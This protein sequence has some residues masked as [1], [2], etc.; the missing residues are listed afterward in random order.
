MNVK[1]VLRELKENKIDIALHNGDIRLSSDNPEIPAAMIRQIREMKKEVID[2]LK[3]HI[4]DDAVIDAIPLLPPQEDYVLSSSQMRLWMVT[5]LA[6][7]GTAYNMNGVYIFKGQ[8][9]E[10]ALEYAFNILMARHESLRT[11]FRNNTSGEVRQVIV[12]L[13]ELEFSLGRIDLRDRADRKEHVRQLLDAAFR[14]P[15]DLLKGPLIRACIYRLEDDEWVFSY[16][17]DH[18]ITDG[19]SMDILFGELQLLYNARISGKENPLSPLRIQYKD[20]AS[21][22]QR[23]FQKPS[24]KRQREYWMQQFA[25]NV[26]VL[27]MPVDKPRPMVKSFRGGEMR[28]YISAEKT[29][30]LRDLCQAEGSTLFMGLLAVINTLIYR[31]SE[32][33]DIVIGSPIAGRVH[34]DLEDQIGFYV[35]TLA[36]RTRISGKDTFR[37]LLTT[38]RDITLGAYQNQ[39][40]PFDELVANLPIQRDM[41]RNP[42]FDVVVALLNHEI[43]GA[44]KKQRPANFEATP[45]KTNE[46]KISKFDLSFVFTETENGL[47]AY[48]EYNTDV[49]LEDSIRQM[50]GYFENL[51]DAILSQPDQSIGLLPLLNEQQQK[52]L[53]I[54]LQAPMVAVQEEGTRPGEEAATEKTVVRLFEEQVNKTPDAIALIFEENSLTYK[55]L[56][57]QANRVAHYL[58]ESC[59]IVPDD[60]VGVRLQRSHRMIVALLGIL[61]AGGAY[62]PIDPEYPD[63][64]VQ[65]I[66][67]DSRCTLLLEEAELKKALTGEYSGENPTAVNIPSHLA[68]VIYTSGSTGLPKGVMVEHKSIVRLVK[69][70]DFVPLTGR[71]TLL[72]TGSLSFDATIFEFW[73][74]LLN[75]GR[76]ILCT[77]QTLLNGTVLEQLIRRWGVDTMWF[78]VSFFNQL[79]SRNI[80]VFSG[81]KTILI[82]GEKLSAE[83]IRILKDRYP[84]VKIINGYGPTENTVFTLTCEIHSAGYIPIGKPMRNTYA[85][86]LNRKGQLQ[87]PGMM[88]EIC[89]GGLGVARGYLYRPE[90]TAEKFV[91]DPYLPGARLYRTGDLGR[92]LP[93]GN[94]EFLGRRDDQLKIRGFRIEPGEIESVLLRH[95]AVKGAVVVAVPNR[96]G[97]KELAAYLVSEE[98]LHVSELRSWLSEALPSYMLPVHY[99]QLSELPLTANGKVDKRALPHPE[100]MEMATGKKYV[101]PR[102]EIETKLVAIWQEMLSRERISVNDDFFELGGHSLKVFR[103]ASVLDKE[104]GVKLKMRDLFMHV[105]LGAQAMLIERAQKGIDAPGQQVEGTDGIKHE[106]PVVVPIEN[107]PLTPDY[108]LSSGQHRLWVLQRFSEDSVAY[109]VPYAYTLRGKIE[110]DL[111]ERALGMIVERHEILRTVFREDGSGEVRQLVLP[112]NASG[113]I[114]VREDVRDRIDK[115]EYIKHRVERM[116][117]EAFDLAKGPLVRTGLFRVEDNEWVFC[118]V[119]H[120]IIVD[121]W[122]M[123]VLIREFSQL[124]TEHSGQVMA[125]INPLPP[126]RIQYKDYAHWQQEQL[127]GQVMKAHR[128]YW[129]RQF[130]GEL[131][132]LELTGS[133][134]RRQL[135]SYRGGKVRREL[136]T[137]EL[138]VLKKFCREEGGTLFMGLLSVLNMLLYRYSG[139]QDIIV[140]SPIAGRDNADLEDQVGFYVNTLALRNRFE[141]TDDFR[142]L[143]QKV[144]KTTLEAYEHHP[145]PFDQLVNALPLQRGMGRNPLFDVLIDFSNL[146]ETIHTQMQQRWFKDFE[147]EKFGAVAP[148]ISKVDLT[149]FLEENNGA[150]SL[151]IE[152]DSDLYSK[153][154]VE[155]MCVHYQQLLEAV[156]AD[157]S[158][159]IEQIDILDDLEKQILKDFNKP[160]SAAPGYTNVVTLFNRQAAA[161]PEAVAVEFGEHRLTYRELNERS[162]ALAAYFADEYSIRPGDLIGIMLPRS[163][164]LIVAILATLK[165]G[166]AFVPLDPEYPATRKKFIIEDTGVKLMVIQADELATL[167]YYEGQ[168]FAIDI[169]LDA[170]VPATP[171]AMPHILPGNTAYLI[172]TSGS[173]GKPKGC[174]IAHQSFANYIQ[175]ANRYYFPEGLIPNFSLFTPV[176]FDLTITSIFCTL[177]SGGTL[178]IY[179]QHADIT[180]I[181]AN[182]MSGRFSANCV[183]LTPSHV[184]MLSQLGL[185]S[186]P[187]VCVILG[188][189]PV[190]RRHVH[191]LKELNPDM[192]IYNEY[193]P[194]EA[195]VGCT[196]ALLSADEPVLIGKPIANTHIYITNAA[197]VLQPAG[198][199]GEIWIGGTGVAK[200]YLNRPDL[201]NEKF[202]MDPFFPGGRIYKTGDRGRWLKNGN[203]EYLGRID[204]QVKIRGHRIEPAEIETALQLHPDIDAAL[205]TATSGAANEKELIAY[206]VTQKEPAV[207]DLRAYLKGLLPAY[208]LPQHYV[209]LDAFPL[210]ANGKVDRKKLPDPMVKGGRSAEQYVAPVSDT[211]KR[212][213]AIWQKV[214]GAEQVGL[215]DDFF[216]MGGHSF[217]ALKIGIEINSAFNTNIEVKHLLQYTTIRTLAE[218]VTA[219]TADEPGNGHPGAPH[220]EADLSGPHYEVTT[221]QVYWLNDE[222]DSE[223]KLTD[224][225]HSSG[226]MIYELQGELD[227][228]MLKKALYDLMRRHES[229]NAS[230]HKMNGRFVMKVN[231]VDPAKLPLQ[232]LEQ[233][234][235]G[236]VNAADAEKF[237]AFN[238]HILKTTRAPLFLIRVVRHNAGYFTFSLNIHH[239]I[240]DGWALDILMRDLVALYNAHKTNTPV[241]LPELKYQLKEHFGFINKHKALNYDTHKA[242]WQGLY[243][244]LPARLTLPGCNEKRTA[245]KDKICKEV[246]YSFTDRHADNLNVLVREHR[247]NLFIVLQATFKSFLFYTTGQKDLLIGTYVLGRD[248]PDSENQIGCLAN[249]KLIRT[250]LNGNDTVREAIRKVQKSN[251][252]MN[253]YNAYTLNDLFSA[254]LPANE[255]LTDGYWKINMQYVTVKEETLSN[256][257]SG[258]G[259]LMVKKRPAETDAVIPIDMQLQFRGSYKNL[260]VDVTY[261][262]SRY[263]EDAIQRLMSGYFN[264]L[265]K[266]T[267]S[268][269]ILNPDKI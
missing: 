55:E 265:E 232:V 178:G 42:L 16:T 18:I 111:L 63:E 130:E 207:A 43:N 40:F 13:N 166:C 186:S 194:T 229:L 80:S 60:L 253:T 91:D 242:Y 252:D 26:P 1:E 39:E 10:L 206:L 177:T 76:L 224:P 53:L 173:T 47:T 96:M 158:R 244:D 254:M 152:Y 243:N 123:A 41:S 27:E 215:N 71:E 73:G 143:L 240:A 61:K 220:D 258:S 70:G 33:E 151:S 11:I 113:F 88:G 191:F 138:A 128:D 218:F 256:S 38:V 223:Y 264:Y 222:I 142:Q 122:S 14:K 101:A 169:Q 182:C 86:V 179:S 89:A 159:P 235:G 94:F 87:P 145:Y 37:Q 81:L 200:G 49:Y 163:E 4:S 106:T 129:M 119:M 167:D 154:W 216:E 66:L 24:L 180:E 112:A 140:G 181:L 48:I 6:E 195:T 225:M 228:D 249:T 190:D 175:W 108:I 3:Q 187:V 156:S 211:E 185:G 64:R 245:L 34:P 21:W 255:S 127:A 208:M 57:E 198:I 247:V 36:L 99:V 52:E 164:K 67:S 20:Y 212:L 234:N 236:A 15:F 219:L 110:E 69:P 124:M 146:N 251:E 50:S 137:A 51:L 261:D 83:Y 260:K 237:L 95:K 214:L 121:G 44:R 65:Y 134:L 82:G 210:S 139:Q 75:G 9:D 28:R 98:V 239:V 233:K 238:D 168:V 269:N 58:R 54:S 257:Y 8:V 7:G 147:L 246:T 78:T 221:T 241:N 68:Y 213:A 102:N 193:G 17:M 230:F 25:D 144:K 250:I 116:F 125:G 93:D 90:L 227:L 46:Y 171:F 118:Y 176:T 107:I 172:Y 226:V 72:S 126:L 104:F 117:H 114:T 2:Y 77:A 62:V 161:T 74:M 5:Q 170:I 192:R 141:G 85:Y 29:S 84:H 31:Y 115:R 135:K 160:S 100:G 97:E 204:E 148:S 217:L 153:E 183:K 165:L 205:V 105:E 35:N 263:Q 199:E 266:M 103:L 259:D 59:A 32:Q 248:I 131:P 184:D 267:G 109:N 120:H 268:G 136:G 196:V 189:E 19:W 12:P 209:C 155:R 262:S 132:V 45:W 150:L 23:W 22:Q 231:E 188:G 202:V 157:P 203:L 30:A 149:F 162:D 92:L 174:E 133:G 201:T 79:V 56:N 197:G